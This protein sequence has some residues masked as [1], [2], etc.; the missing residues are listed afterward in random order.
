MNTSGFNIE[1]RGT[2][3]AAT[4]AVD[5]ILHAA[6]KAAKEEHSEE[7]FFEHFD[8]FVPAGIDERDLNAALEQAKQSQ[9][10]P[11]IEVDE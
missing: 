10:W 5:Q 11:W 3:E 8:T 1:E 2:V 9:R 6:K 7:Y 4:D